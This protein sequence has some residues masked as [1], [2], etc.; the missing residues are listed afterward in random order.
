[1]AG[2]RDNDPKDLRYLRARSRIA[3]GEAGWIVRT[4][5]G[6]KGPFATE[7]EAWAYASVYADTTRFLHDAAGSLPED[8]DPSNFEV[9]EIKL[10][11]WC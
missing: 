7:A 8:V 4:R 5:E 2:M 6:T 3:K 1:M 10:P 11:R 9:I